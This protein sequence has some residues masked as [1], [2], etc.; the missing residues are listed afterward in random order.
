MPIE[1]KS[2]YSGW[3]RELKRLRSLP[4]GAGKKKLDFVLA[5]AYTDVKGQ[6]HVDTSS[7]KNSA[8]KKSR[9][10]KTIWEGKI[11]VGGATRIP[12]VHNPVN[13]AGYERQR[14]GDHDFLR[15]YRA[16]NELFGEAIAD[17]LGNRY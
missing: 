3:K 17:I 16:Y 6:I 1:V 2:D 13:Y 10:G 12:S 14:D 7:L 8:R 4:G 5:L 9:S 11:T 15:D